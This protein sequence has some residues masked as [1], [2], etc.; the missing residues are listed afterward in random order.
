M[1]IM[2]NYHFPPPP[3]PEGCTK[4]HLK[5][6]DDLRESLGTDV[7]DGMFMNP[8]SMRE[9]ELQFALDKDEAS[10]IVVYWVNNSFERHKSS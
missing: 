2:R 7:L 4:E 6:L 1:T 10:D 3:K 5:Y 8:R 9:F